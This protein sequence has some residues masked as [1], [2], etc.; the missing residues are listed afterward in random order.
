MR[1]YTVAEARA[2]L[3]EVVPVLE[4]LQSAIRRLKA[5]E[6]AVAADARGASGDGNLI[7]TP[8]EH[9]DAGKDLEEVLGAQVR[10]SAAALAGWDIELKDAERGLIDF[11]HLRNGEDVYLCYMLGEPGIQ[12]WHPIA[13]GFAGRAPIGA[14][15]D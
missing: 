7:T 13:A 14:D 2:L 11:H 4:T 5:L 10:R 8:W 12:F 1:L 9:G 15:E 6:A 3:P